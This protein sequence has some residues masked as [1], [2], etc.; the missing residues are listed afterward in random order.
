MENL[1]NNLPF[2]VVEGYKNLI[3]DEKTKAILNTNFNEYENYKKMKEIKHEEVSRI[4]N[5]EDDLKNIKDDIDEIKF[6][7]RN[8]ANGS[9]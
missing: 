7:L 1:H 9:K 8:I 4:N 3:R 6:L 2:S 5:L